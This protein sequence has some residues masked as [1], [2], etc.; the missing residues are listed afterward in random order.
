MKIESATAL[1]KDPRP[2]RLPGKRKR[3][4]AN[5]RNK[6]FIGWDGE[7][8]TLAGNHH[9]ALFGNSD[10]LRATGRLSWRQTLPLLFQAPRNAYH[11]IF[12][13]TY[14]CVMM[15]RD[16]PE[17]DRLLHGEPVY[18]DQYRVT[19]LKGKMLRVTDRERGETRILYDVFT[20]FGT[21]FVK[22][23]REYLGDSDTLDEIEA[24]KLQRNTF[25][26]DDVLNGAVDPY[27]TQEL[28]LLVDL[29]QSLRERLAAV[30]IHPT[31]WHGPG[32][33][34]S[35]V[36]KRERIKEH[37]GSYSD[38]FRRVAE[39]A[40]YGGR[41]EQF[42]RGTFLGPVYQYDIRSAY[43]AA[44]QDLPSLVGATWERELIPY[45]IGPYDLCY[46]NCA[47]TS[48]SIG[49]LPHRRKDGTIYYPK[50]AKGWYWGIEIP[51][52][53]HPY[54][55]KMYKCTL[56]SDVKPF[57]YINQMYEQRAQLK[58][59]GKPEQLALKLALNSGYGKLAQSKGARN[60]PGTGWKYP[61]FH[62]V[63][64]AGL[65][66]ATTR[67]SISDALHSVDSANIIATE[68]D[69]VFSTTPLTLRMG[70]QLGDWDEETLNGIKYI[71]SGVSLVLS[72][73]EWKFKTRGFTVK[74]TEDENEIWS[75]FLE[76]SPHRLDM[77]QTRFGTDPRQRER[78]GQWYE[79]IHHLTLD[80]ND[81]EKRVHNYH[82]CLSCW[83]GHTYGDGLHPL[84]VPSIPVVDSTPYKFLWHDDG[85]PEQ[86]DL[87]WIATDDPL[88]KLEYVT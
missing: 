64:W 52:T 68:T 6:P 41:F 76:L 20:F 61:T 50:F 81:N 3:A 2:N 43:P 13:G 78:F 7:G 65:I 66:T 46:I 27:M 56:A 5:T 48:S 39:S 22:A 33:V 72:S 36:F 86:T 47:D 88:L 40:Y 77:K 83:S 17:V 31:Q 21:S 75:R 12:A 55:R 38:E 67:R 26:K 58:R 59:E 79:T 24:M 11:V 63:V 87:A 69:S 9:Y 8:Y 54:V 16:H 42:Q 60:E 44:M 71:Q 51:E 85:A 84:I 73:N 25:T 23:C 34:A 62:D 45:D 14:D 74:R 19:F 15:F 49:Y 53:L 32:A 57:A 70:S 29:C 80:V 35:A 10:G 30:G 1:T 28:R 37:K 18:M 4:Q 82:E